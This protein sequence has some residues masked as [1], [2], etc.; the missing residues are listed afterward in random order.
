MGS[1][2]DSVRNNSKRIMSSVDSKCYE[3]AKECFKLTVSYSP[4]E[5]VGS[6]WAVGYLKNQW[7]V[8]DGKSFS[9]GINSVASQSGDDSLRRISQLSGNQF[10]MKDGAVTLSNN[11][12]HAYRVEVLGWPTPKWTGTV[13]PYRMVARAI[14]ETSAKHK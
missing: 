9:S 1:F 14:A 4:S 8:Y 2:A 5:S 13:M 12:P 7:Y 11:V 3:I 10:Y 6:K